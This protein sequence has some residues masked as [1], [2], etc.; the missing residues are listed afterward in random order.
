M[1][2]HEI[3]DFIAKGGCGRLRDKDALQILAD[4]TAA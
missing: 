1:N 2:W 4:A 3:S